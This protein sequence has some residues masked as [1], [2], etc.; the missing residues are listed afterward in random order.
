M[1]RNDPLTTH[2]TRHTGKIN[3]A[4]DGPAGAGK[5]TVAQLVATE[6]QYVYVDT[7][8]MYRA[9]TLHM[10]RAGISPHNV[11]QVLASA[12]QLAIHIDCTAHGQKVL[13]NGEDVTEHLRSHEVTERV[14]S[15]A[16]IKGMRQILVRTQRDLALPK[17][18]VM[19]GRDIGTTVLPDAEVKV[20]MTASVHARAQRR[21]QQMH[22][23]ERTTLEQLKVDMMHRDQLDERR[24]ES[25]LRRAPDAIL[26]DT[27]SLSIEQVAAQIVRL[28]TIFHKEV[29]L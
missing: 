22:E 18:V 24:E 9:V 17:G 3:I 5:S 26:L 12:E 6:L 8:A 7:G 27:T 19:D 10:M 1:R 13:C 20:F 16:Q 15:Y 28:C 11:D 29:N 21:F 23:A 4:I 25:P 2:P 14:S